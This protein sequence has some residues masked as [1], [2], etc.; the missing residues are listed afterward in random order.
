MSR[1]VYAR[2]VDDNQKE[3][4]NLWRKMEVSVLLL[5][6]VGNGCPDML[7]GFTDYQGKP[8]NILVEVKD[9]KKPLSAQKLTMGE[10]EFFNKWQGQVCIIRSK[11]EAKELINKYRLP[12]DDS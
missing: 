4:T 11:T 5:H 1:G 6:V 12:P 3:L 8:V 2:R 7:L 9:G 10:V